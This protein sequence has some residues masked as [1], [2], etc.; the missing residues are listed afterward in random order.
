MRLT[1]EDK[2]EAFT[3]FKGVA[4]KNDFLQS[5]CKYEHVKLILDFLRVTLWCLQ[6]EQEV[7]RAHVK[8]VENLQKCDY[9]E[10]LLR[11][12][13]DELGSDKKKFALCGNSRL[14]YHVPLLVKYTRQTQLNDLGIPMNLTTLRMKMRDPS[15]V[16][17]RRAN[18]F[19]YNS[20]DRYNS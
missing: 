13:R 5:S 11:R 12:I 2:E 18:K 7:G 16:I 15:P 14:G 6:P 20:Y 9:L 10:F 17:D 4:G 19:T 1:A 3:T 8:L